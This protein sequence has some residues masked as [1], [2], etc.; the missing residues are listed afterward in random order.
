MFGF[1]MR[2]M[3]RFCRPHRRRSMKRILALPEKKCGVIVE[4]FEWDHET[5]SERG[6]DRHARNHYPT[7]R[8]AHTAAEIAERTTERLACAAD[9]CVLFIGRPFRTLP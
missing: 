1:Q 4:D 6:K 9:D 7:A 2:F 3:L 8:D 5:W